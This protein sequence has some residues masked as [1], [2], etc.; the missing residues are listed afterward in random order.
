M[1][2]MS[3]ILDAGSPG[4]GSALVGKVTGCNCGKI[5]I[6]ESELASMVSMI[7]RQS[8]LINKLNRKLVE[9][10]ETIKDGMCGAWDCGNCYPGND[11]ELAEREA[12]D[13]YME[14]K[15]EYAREQERDA[16]ERAIRMGI[17]EFRADE[18]E[19]ERMSDI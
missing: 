12:R 19:P 15:A 18:Y 16:E 9:A 8:E 4:G 1:I 5:K 17:G 6:G 7:D 10:E 3:D 2:E 11:Y 13:E 14:Q